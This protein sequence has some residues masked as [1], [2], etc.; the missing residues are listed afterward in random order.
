MLKLSILKYIYMH[1]H[2]RCSNNRHA[3]E[4]HLYMHVHPRCHL[5]PTF[6]LAPHGRGWPVTSVTGAT[7]T[8]GSRIKN[9]I[10]NVRS[11]A[12]EAAQ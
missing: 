1:V 5:G 3:F 8:V 9:V 4:L 6:Y 2:P 12:L 10:N 11:G 7:R